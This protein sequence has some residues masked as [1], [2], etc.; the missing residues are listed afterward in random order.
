HDALPIWQLDAI[1]PTG[2]IAYAPL[3]AVVP[4]KVHRATHPADR[5]FPR[6]MSVIKRACGSPKIPCTR[7][8]VL[9]PANLYASDRRR[10]LRVLGIESSCQNFA[11]P[12]LTLNPI[13]ISLTSASSPQFHP[14]GFTKTQRSFA[15]PT[16]ASPRLC[17]SLSSVLPLRA[18]VCQE[19][20][21][22]LAAWKEAAM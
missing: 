12:Q 14:L 1:A 4:P 6:R 10:C 8:N 16:S 7:D 3:S 21:I 17:E 22:D 18:L 11:A 9:N 19:S 5:F 20:L 15:R 2:Q 13:I